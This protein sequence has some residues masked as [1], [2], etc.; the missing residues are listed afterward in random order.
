MLWSY[1]MWS[2]LK[3]QLLE[4]HSPCPT[5]NMWHDTGERCSDD[6]MTPFAGHCLILSDWSGYKPK[7]TPAAGSE[8]L[9]S[10]PHFICIQ[11]NNLVC[12]TVPV[13]Q[14][15][16]DAL[17]VFLCLQRPG[18]LHLDFICKP[19]QWVSQGVCLQL[20]FNVSL[21]L[22]TRNH[23]RSVDFVWSFEEFTKTELSY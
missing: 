6:S 2:N 22:P 18:L 7:P 14:L 9:S 17:D 15:V 1:R 3:G 13:A 16:H 20:H 12:V 4:S 21:F 5:M 11:L 10:V 8:W 19:W 23:K